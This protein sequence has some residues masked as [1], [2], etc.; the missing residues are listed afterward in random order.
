MEANTFAQIAACEQRSV[1]IEG[2]VSSGKTQALIMR[3]ITLLEN[4]VEPEEILVTCATSYAVQAFAQRL[5]AALPECDASKV[6]RMEICTP[7]QII[8]KTLNKDDVCVQTKRPARLLSSF[9]YNFVL[10]DMKTL[11]QSRR[12][13]R[14]M[15][16]FIY[17][18]WAQLTPESEWFYGDIVEVCNKLQG[19]CAALGSV[20]SF[21]APYLCAT[22][23]KSDEGQPFRS[24][25]SYVLCDDFQNLSYA[26]QTALCLHA[27]KQLIVAG[28][29]A[30]RQKASSDYVY[31]EG[32]GNFEKT[33][34]NVEVF[35]LNQT[36]G[37]GA[38][39]K[40]AAA[41]DMERHAEIS[42]E[43]D[44]APV[45]RIKWITPK[46]EMVGIT[47]SLRKRFND[48]N[49]LLECDTCLIVPN[50]RFGRM[51][52]KALQARGF[53]TS[54]TGLGSFIG[55]D[56][57][58]TQTC[59]ALFAYVKLNLIAH[60]NDAVAWRAW[61]GF[62]DALCNSQSFEGL[63]RY[64]EESGKPLV[65]CL[66]D[67]AENMETNKKE[68]FLRAYVLATRYEQGM[69]LI[70]ENAQ[71]RGFNVLSAVGAAG[72]P[73]FESVESQLE[74]AETV[75]EVFA[76]AQQS[77]F[78]PTLSDDPR[79]LNIMSYP[80]MAGLSFNNIVAVAMIDGYMPNRAA[81][82]VVSTEEDRNNVMA[83]EQRALYNA[84]GKAREKLMLS[85]F[86]KCDLELAE[87]T[88]A[89]V[90]RVR[91]EDGA[92]IA[93]CTP[94]CFF[95]EMEQACPSTVSGQAFLSEQDLI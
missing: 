52:E 36:H 53:K 21:E 44:K 61:C 57:R 77:V 69:S 23:L 6:D 73:E 40:V 88:K 71:R 86:A 34:R 4:G 3:C 30:Q 66:K 29:M 83:S 19:F 31:A 35:H 78:A 9:E 46:D 33:R 56:P 87:R 26:E 32:F 16:K 72:L 94:S 18:N 20:S 64:I 37:N 67:V 63:Y 15:L 14:S 39:Q 68:P 7:L 28:N 48:D 90:S 58:N 12:E 38:I 75:D 92:R 80:S 24:A 81:F 5:R 76:L 62:E 41:L 55:G 59:P 25:Y 1:K 51:Y 85:Y 79:V 8:V 45:Q 60:P 91:S 93:L 65:E 10:E 70:N 11:G 74:G 50:K 95:T 47:K 89:Q 42:F 17:R 27:K 13:L 54:L 22:L 49:Q 84:L 43:A 82:E 2:P